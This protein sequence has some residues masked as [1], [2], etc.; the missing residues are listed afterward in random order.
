VHSYLIAV[1]FVV[2]ERT[3]AEKLAAIVDFL[4]VA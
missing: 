1:F 2:E 4:I 3:E